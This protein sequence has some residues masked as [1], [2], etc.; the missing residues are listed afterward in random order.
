MADIVNEA[1]VREILRSY[2]HHHGQVR[3][4][5]EPYEKFMSTM[6]PHIIKE[7]SDITICLLYTSP[8]PRD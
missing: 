7:N 5:M 6:L 2:F 8:S 1:C 4:Q 3:V